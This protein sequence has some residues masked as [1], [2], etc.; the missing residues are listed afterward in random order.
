[1]ATGGAIVGIYSQAGVTFRSSLKFLSSSGGTSSKVR[2]ARGKLFATLLHDEPLPLLRVQQLQLT[3]DGTYDT[4]GAHPS[5]RLSVLAP[6]D[7]AEVHL[8]FDGSRYSS[9][10]RADGLHFVMTC[11]P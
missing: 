3:V 11:S 2:G 6:V 1:L 8:E 5:S 7:F 10:R 4:S 9:I